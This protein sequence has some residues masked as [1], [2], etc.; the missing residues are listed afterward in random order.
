MVSYGFFDSISGDRLYSAEDFTNFLG[1]LVSDGVIANP[2]ASLQVQPSNGMTIKV[3]A[4]WA[5]ILHHYV[6]N[7][8]DLFLTLDAADVARNRCDRIVIRYIRTERRIEIAVKK[9][10][11]LES[12]DPYLPDLQRDANIWEMSLAYIYVYANAQEITAGLIADERPDTTVCGWV[13]GMI[14]QIDTTNLFAQYDSAFWSWFNGIK[15][16]QNAYVCNGINDNVTLP[17]FIANLQSTNPNINGIT[18]IGTFGIDDTVI[19]TGSYLS[20]VS[21]WIDCEN[22]NHITIDF[23]RCSTIYHDKSYDFALFVNCTIQNLNLSINQIRDNPV[24]RYA[25]YISTCI[26]LVGGTLEHCSVVGTVSGE[27]S[28]FYQVIKLLDDENVVR[29]CSIDVASTLE[30]QALGIFSSENDKI[31]DCKIK[32]T[33]KI[34]TG[35]YAKSSILSNCTVTALAEQD[36][37]GIHIISSCFAV[38]C[39]MTGYTQNDAEYQGCGIISTGNA[40]VYLNGIRSVANPPDLYSCTNSMKLSDGSTG[41]YTGIFSPAISAPDIVATS[42]PIRRVTKAEY[43]AIENPSSIVLYCIK[44]EVI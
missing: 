30:V 40:D 11:S 27:V 36:G 31:E 4:G 21:M 10:E 3:T 8:A 6:H 39:D 33:G 1:N 22:K 12:G 35:I 37:S 18:V 2:S 26:Q 16:T 25:A 44:E 20:R 38:N 42:Q 14:Q 43:D 7:D 9:G 17:A 15:E 32:I 13:T 29:N 24:D 5:Y 41:F 19:D 23:S 34:A 28:P